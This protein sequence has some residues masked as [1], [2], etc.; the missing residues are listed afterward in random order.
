MTKPQTK[1]DESVERFYS[2]S[3]WSQGEDG[4]TLDA[5]LFEDLREVA[6]EYL[7]KCRLRTL[8]HIPESGENILD[9]ASGP[10]QYDEYLE[11][12]KGFKT[13]HC[14]DL[15]ADALA[16]AEKKIGAHGRYYQGNFMEADFESG[17]FDCS[18]SL[19]TIYHIDRD[20]QEAAVRK[21][22]DVTRRSAPVVIIYSN[23]RSL[24][25][26]LLSPI[27]RTILWL[28]RRKAAEPG[29]GELYFHAHRLGWWKRFEDIADVKV[30]PWRSF[31]SRLQRR[32]IPGT[33][34]GGKMFQ[35]LF[36]LEERF[37]RLAARFG[38]YPMVVLT[39][40]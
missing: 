31:S 17:F 39:K 13:R 9:M 1:S 10:I 7:R 11:Y 18:I 8:Q 22:V 29:E 23:P 5:V 35:L 33:A 21:L 14:V 27:K 12:S 26:M 40:K 15:S 38:Q 32:I 20:R 24:P 6:A 37:P 4:A 16:Q 36:W 28:K 2:D 30:Y 19:H 34:V 3:G 25:Q